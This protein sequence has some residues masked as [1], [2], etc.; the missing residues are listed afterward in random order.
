VTL[1]NP[2]Q[3]VGGIAVRTPAGVELRPLGRDD[4]AVAVAMARELR[5][6]PAL[7]DVRALDARYE[8]LINSPDIA[9]LLALRDGEAAGL[10]VLHFRRRLN[11]A[12]FEGWL[13]DLFVRPEARGQGIGRALAQGAV[14]EWRLR[15]GHRLQAPV[16]LQGEACRPT[17]EALGFSEWMTEFVQRPLAVPESSLSSGVTIRP[18]AAADADP[19]TR[20][21]AE[22]GPHRS[23]V[24]ERMEAVLRTFAAHARMVAAGAA[25]SLVAEQDGAVVGVCVMDWREP[26]WDGVRQAWIHDLVITE[27]M[28]GRGIGRAMLAAG[29]AAAREAGAGEVQLEARR[30]IAQRLYRSVGFVESGRTWVLQRDA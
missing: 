13:S 30:E 9:P 2:D 16:P 15:Q 18:L 14:A 28:R 29:L 23:P 4:Q 21:I 1:G 24:P 7:D 19:V 12:T 22:F 26:F 3:P 11:F 5:G 6:L 17:L 8:R 27:P 10:A 20:L 25:G